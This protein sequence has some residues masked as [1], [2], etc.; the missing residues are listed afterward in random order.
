MESLQEQVVCVQKVGRALEV[1]GSRLLA[2]S[3]TAQE[4]VLKHPVR[5]VI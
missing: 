4:T 2:V 1:C 5:I 3:V